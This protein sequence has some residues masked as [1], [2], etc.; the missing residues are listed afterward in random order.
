[1]N[2]PGKGGRYYIDENG[3]RH[4]IEPDQAYPK[5]AKSVPKKPKSGG[6]K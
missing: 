6:S 5:P 4:K 3:K 1:M 2:T